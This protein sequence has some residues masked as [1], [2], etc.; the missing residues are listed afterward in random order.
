LSSAEPLL[1]ATVSW[2]PIGTTA[3]WLKVIGWWEVLIGITFLFKKTT[4]VAIRLLFLQ[5]IGN[6][7]PLLF[8]PEITF[9]K[10]NYMLP[11]L[12]GNISQRM[13]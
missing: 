3:T 6:F 4:K 8:L 10:G 9:E 5:M 1:K 13:L 11:T 2:I 7:M 12:G